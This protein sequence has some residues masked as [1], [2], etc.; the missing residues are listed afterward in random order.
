MNIGYVKSDGSQVV[1]EPTYQGG[2]VAI[3]YL[4]TTIG[5]L[6]GGSISDH[7]GRIRTVLIGCFFAIFGAALQVKF[8]SHPPDTIRQLTHVLTPQRLAP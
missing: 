6:M 4:G 5:T 2:I 3:Y 8:I 1:T 7:I